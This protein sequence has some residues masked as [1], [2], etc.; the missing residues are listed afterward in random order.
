MNTNAQ[1]LLTVRCNRDQINKIPELQNLNWKDAFPEVMGSD[2]TLPGNRMR[3]NQITLSFED[4]TEAKALYS[5]L[6]QE[7]K[8]VAFRNWL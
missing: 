6:Q 8:V 3:Q 5:K 2:P 4:Q 1:T 7:Y